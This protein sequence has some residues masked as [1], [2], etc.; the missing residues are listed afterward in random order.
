MTRSDASMLGSIGTMP[1]DTRVAASRLPRSPGSKISD[2]PGWRGALRTR[3]STADMRALMSS[4]LPSSEGSSAS[5]KL[6]QFFSASLSLTAAPTSGPASSST[7][8]A[9]LEPLY[10]LSNTLIAPPDRTSSG[11]TV[12]SPAA[13]IATPAGTG[14]PAALASSTPN[15]ANAAVA[16]SIVTGPDSDGMEIAMGFVPNT[17]FFAPCGAT[18]SGDC[19][20]TM[21]ISP[22]WASSSAKYPIAPVLVAVWFV[23]TMP[24]PARVA[25]STAMSTAC[26][27]TSMPVPLFPLITALRLVS[28]SM[29]GGPAFGALLRPPEV[30]FT[31]PWLLSRSCAC[32]STSNR[33]LASS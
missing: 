4:G 1:A 15:H 28:C 31:M 8:S 14:C 23:P 32:M 26:F 11:S 12:S 30:I 9:R 5:T 18:N 6:P 20:S 7:I 16:M 2:T 33:T 22:R 17:A 24:M 13:L 21:P 3:S 27:S 25:R 10:D 29:M 19:A